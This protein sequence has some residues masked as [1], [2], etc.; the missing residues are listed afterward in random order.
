MIYVFHQIVQ[1]SRKKIN[2]GH[3]FTLVSQRLQKTL[4]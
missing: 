4:Q 3:G 1:D 2:I